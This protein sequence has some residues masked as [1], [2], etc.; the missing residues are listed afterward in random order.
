M[1]GA[2]VGSSTNRPNG[3]DFLILVFFYGNPESRK[4]GQYSDDRKVAIVQQCLDS[5][6]TISKS[7][8]CDHDHA[9]HGPDDYCVRFTSIL[10][11]DLH[12]RSELVSNRPPPPNRSSSRSQNPEFG[13]SGS[14]VELRLNGFDRCD[15]CLRTGV[16][17]GQPGNLTD[18]EPGQGRQF[19]E[20]GN[21]GFRSD[22][23]LQK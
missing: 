15:S 2:Y 10:I 18:I 9:D 1:K 22:S 13:K 16:T 20:Q 5:R 17:C 12:D 8:G 6:E 4:R 19:A 14:S 11:V 23:R 21:L 3:C 7:T